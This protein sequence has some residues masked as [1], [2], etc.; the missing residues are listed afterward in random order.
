MIQT[1]G[2]LQLRRGGFGVC[3][4]SGRGECAAAELLVVSDNLS[5]FDANV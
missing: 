2:R 1:S 4:L 3:S 5:F